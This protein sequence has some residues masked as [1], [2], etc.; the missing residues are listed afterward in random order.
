MP[1]PAL[2]V[3]SAFGPVLA[4]A[5]GL[6]IGERFEE[7]SPPICPEPRPCPPCTAD[8]DWEESTAKIRKLLAD[9]NQTVELCM[10]KLDE[11]RGER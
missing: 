6:T 2:L 1:N 5:I 11:C 10:F 8:R 4:F 9:Y 3:W 7:P